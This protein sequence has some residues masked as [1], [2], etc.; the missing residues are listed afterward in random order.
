MKAKTKAQVKSTISE[1][2]VILVATAMVIGIV[3]WLRRSHSDSDSNSDSYVTSE[4]SCVVVDCRHNNGNG[5]YVVTVEDRQGNLWDY[6][7][8]TYMA[9]GHIVAVTFS[10]SEIIAIRR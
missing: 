4:Q 9:N 3:V 2:L 8:D 10:D 1:I 5:L 7:D 6:Y